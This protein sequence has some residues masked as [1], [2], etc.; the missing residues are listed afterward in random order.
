MSI[1][2][3]SLIAAVFTLIFGALWHMP[4]FGKKWGQAL[5]MTMP[6]K[7]DMKPMYVRMLI[8]FIASYITAFV[9]FLFLYNFRAGN[10]GQIMITLAVIFIGFNLTQLV[11]TNLWNGRPTKDALVLFGISAGYQIINL[12]VW[13]LLFF[14][15]A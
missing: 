13:G 2:L 6:A 1:F 10:F 7:P 15:I 4:L 3:L 9:T 8:N 11:V 14:W 12:F 5:G